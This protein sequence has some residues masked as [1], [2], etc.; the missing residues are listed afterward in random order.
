MSS[1]TQ[2]STRLDPQPDVLAWRRPD[3]AFLFNHRSLSEYE[4][5]IWKGMELVQKQVS[6]TQRPFSGVSPQALAASFEDVD[7]DQSLHSLSDALDEVERLY[8]NDAVYFHHP[9]YVAHLNCPIAIPAILAELILSSINSSLDTWDQSAGGTFIE[10]KLIDWT[11]SR[12]GLGTRADGVFTSGGTQSNLMAMLLARETCCGSLS[13]PHAGRLPGLSEDYRKLR[14]FTSQASHF[15]IRKAASV[16]GLGY[17]AVISVPTDSRFRMNARALETRIKAS[18]HDGLIPMAV[19]ATAGTTDF[20]SIDPMEDIARICRRYGLWLHA[21]AAYGCGL[22]VSRKYR[23]RLDGIQHADSVTVD[24]HKSFFQPVSCGAL[25]V[26]DRRHLGCVTYHADYLNP[27]SQREEGT[28]NLVDKSMQ[29]T[30]RFDALKLWLTL[31]A[32]GAETIGNAFDQV[33]ALAQ[34]VYRLFLADD[35]IDVI[36][37]PE[38]SALVFRYRPSPACPEHELDAANTFIRKALFRSGDAVVAGTRVDGRQ[39]LKFTLLNPATTIQDIR[40]IR[41]LIKSHGERYFRRG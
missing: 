19:V 37:Q 41:D 36:H 14:I 30:K 13:E 15:S 1:T 39:Y 10:Q 34:Q 29:T 22:L 9:K 5:A 32:V 18:L 33:I 7:L 4:E 25:L 40:E 26:K 23:S 12:I 17:D 8:L 28:P 6:S 31:R 20:G 35:A 38:L 24:Y 16:L 21:D 11:A 27:R 2:P 3:A